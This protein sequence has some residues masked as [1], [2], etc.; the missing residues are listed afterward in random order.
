[1]RTFVWLLVALIVFSSTPAL[2]QLPSNESNLAR[3][4]SEVKQLDI[5]IASLQTAWDNEAARID[6]AQ[7]S[8][9]ERRV[10]YERA[11]GEY[12]AKLAWLKFKRSGKTVEV[13]DSLAQVYQNHAMNLLWSE[14]RAPITDNS[15]SEA[16]RQAVN[17]AESDALTKAATDLS[18]KICPSEV[19]TLLN[20]P[21]IM[22]TMEKV[23]ADVSEG[24]GKPVKV[25]LSPTNVFEVRARLQV[26]PASSNP[27]T[28]A[29]QARRAE[30]SAFRLELLRQY[31]VLV[32]SNRLWD[33]KL[34]LIKPNGAV[35]QEKALT[36]LT[37]VIENDQFRLGKA[38][39]DRD[40]PEANGAPYQFQLMLNLPEG[41]NGDQARL[42]IVML[43]RGPKG[44][45]Q[46][47]FSLQGLESAAS[48]EYQSFSP[49]TITLTAGLSSLSNSRLRVGES[50]IRFD[51][52]KPSQVAVELQNGEM[53][54]YSNGKLTRR[55]KYDGK[56]GSLKS[57][58]L[59]LPSTIV[60]DSVKLYDGGI[61][62]ISE[63][64]NH[65]GQSNIRMNT[66]YL[67]K[68]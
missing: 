45:K 14:G 58:S 18:S 29:A 26:K 50:I 31:P 38:I 54:A 47:G 7:L 60:L 37:G 68:Q 6:G 32:E 5:D 12:T 8:V 53:A 3:S 42:E 61:L 33:G 63:D 11:K 20:H 40:F 66:E 22:I 51:A 21:P 13:L 35:V 2:A 59:T 28:A 17:A 46:V 39:L 4:L 57:L 49:P 15:T 19:L 64:F 43:E 36:S 48:Y 65:D 67:K 25:K 9:Q 24:F 55:I 16:V 27:Y 41:I 1:M 10:A 52:D 62:V 30:L 56:V 34:I 44:L 23:S